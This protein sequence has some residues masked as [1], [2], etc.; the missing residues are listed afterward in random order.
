MVNYF[1]S[2]YIFNKVDLRTNLYLWYLTLSV[3]YYL[4]KTKL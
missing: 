2:V 4:E 1:L 3:I